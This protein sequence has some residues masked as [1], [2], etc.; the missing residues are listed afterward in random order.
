MGA[1]G[2]FTGNGQAKLEGGG[3][4]LDEWASGTLEVSPNGQ[5]SLYGGVLASDLLGDATPTVQPTG[6]VQFKLD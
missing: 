4:E 5:W 2:M 3:L 6:G 1:G